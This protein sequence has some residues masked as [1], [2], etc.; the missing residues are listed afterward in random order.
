QWI[1]KGFTY[2]TGPG[3]TEMI[4]NIRNNAPGGGG[5]DWAIDDI[6]VATCSPTLVMNP[7]TP[8][9]NVCYGDGQSLSAE[10][11][12]YYDNFTHYIWERSLDNGVTWDLTS[13]TGVAT[14]TNTGTEYAYTATGPS[15]IGDSTTH[16]NQYRLR[17]ASSA[18]NLADVDCSFRATRTIQ[19][20][21]H[22][23][24]YV[25][26]TKVLNFSGTLQHSSGVLNWVTS[27]EEPGVSYTIEKSVDGTKYRAIGSVN[28]KA[29]NGF[30][31]N[32]Q[33]T[34]PVTLTAPTY[35]RI[36][37]T[38]HGKPQYTKLVLLS[39]VTVAF[40]VK[41]VLSPFDNQL[42]FDVLAPADGTAK[43]S[44]LDNFGRVVKTFNQQVYQ[45]LTPVKTSQHG[46]VANGVYVLKVEYGNALIIK[47]MVKV[48]K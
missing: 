36:L 28:G 33:F 2:R 31:S 39:P 32:Y 1:K 41:N 22:N 43:V 37:V 6:G 23:C 9:V 16:N 27:N 18:T 10:V 40:D 44:I 8:T 4:I 20:L 34:D 48:N 38:E 35:Y 24:L 19:V 46:A 13:F 3:E 17:V 45:G 15:L 47:R 14:P 7:A 5:N 21:V 12:S 30:G 26:K 29:A 25:L 11:I 42:S